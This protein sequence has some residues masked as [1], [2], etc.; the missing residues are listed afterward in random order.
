MKF[1]A[2]LA[3]DDIPESTGDLKAWSSLAKFEADPE[4]ADDF[5]EAKNKAEEIDDF[6]T[7]A[8]VNAVTMNATKVASGVTVLAV[9][10][11]ESGAAK[12]VAVPEV[13]AA[14]VVSFELKPRLRTLK[15]S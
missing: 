15:I 6:K 13:K 3:A 10:L 7:E 14:D 1:K 4:G 9:G 8:R 5:A 12:A 11:I 2:I